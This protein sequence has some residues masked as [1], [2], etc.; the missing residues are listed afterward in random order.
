MHVITVITKLL[1]KIIYLYTFSQSMK[2]SGILVIIVIINSH[3]K[4]VYPNTLN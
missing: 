3:I 4:V 2:V 1:R